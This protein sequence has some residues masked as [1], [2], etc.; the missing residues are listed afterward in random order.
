MQRLARRNAAVK[1]QLTCT[2]HLRSPHPQMYTLVK[3]VDVAVDPNTG[4][5]V[6]G[7]FKNLQTGKTTV[8]AEEEE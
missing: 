6:K 8:A 1:L 5:K 4:K 7:G 3:Y 2:C